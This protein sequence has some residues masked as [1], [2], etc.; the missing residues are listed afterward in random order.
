AERLISPTPRTLRALLDWSHDLLS[1]REK[2]L[3]RRLCVFPASFTASFAHAVCAEPRQELWDTLDTLA[4]LAEK[5]VVVRSEDGRFRLL[6]SLRN[7]ASQQ[8]PED[9]Y[10]F[11]MRKRSRS[12]WTPYAEHSP[13]KR[14]RH[15][16]R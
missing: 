10:R 2:T 5:S 6:E 1:P 14:K 11:A 12:G 9:L 16:C 4:D 7:Y 8:Q 15:H 3:F 13:A